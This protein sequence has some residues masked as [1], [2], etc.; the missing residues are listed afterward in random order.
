MM[1]L[2]PLPLLLMLSDPGPPT[3]PQNMGEWVGGRGGGGWGG[4]DY[5]PPLLY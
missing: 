3:P 1:H 4:G 5:S 2:T